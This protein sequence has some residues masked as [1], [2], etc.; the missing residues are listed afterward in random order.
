MIGITDLKTGVAIDLEGD[1]YVVMNYQHSKMGRGGAVMR[2]KLRNLRT[3]ALV[4]ITFK[5]SDKF[6]EADLDRR[7][8]SFLYSEGTDSVFMDSTSFE[9]YSLSAEVVGDK[10]RFLRE[11][12]EVLILFYQDQPVSIDL[13]IKMEFEI[14]HTEP[15]VKG[16]TAQGGSKPATLDTGAT[17]TVPLFVKTGDMIRVNTVEGTYVERVR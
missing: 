8:S 16:D 4:D 14:T 9:Q 1:P 2:T 6:E 17:I 5:G 10:S 11:G 12:S 7:A 13:P 3:G 15:G